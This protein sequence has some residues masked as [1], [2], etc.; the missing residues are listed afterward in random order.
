[1]AELHRINRRLFLSDVGRRTVAIAVL[2][3]GVL[4]ACSSDGELT[5]ETPSNEPTTTST[6]A[7]TTST[8]T[9]E[10]EVTTSTLSS[11]S[12]EDVPPALAWQRVVLGG[13]SAYVL[14]R[15]DEVTI[16]DTG[17]SGSAPQIEEALMTLGA[18]WSHVG[19]VIL[20]HLHSDHIG[21]LPGILE[22]TATATVHAGRA[23]VEAITASREVQ[24]LDDGDEIFGLQ[25]IATP[26]HTPGHIAVLD[27]A[28]GL[29]VAG[30]ALNESDGMVLGP[31]PSFTPD[32]NTANASVQRL[33]ERS[34]ET[35]VFG[36]GNPI[37]G[38][39]SDA[40]VALAQT[41]S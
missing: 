31:N 19:R 25:I 39:A 2:G 24:A 3:P 40:V 37:E 12:A 30:D 32:M 26:G 38:G 15:G 4:A 6:A 5:L 21:G 18:D 11:P 33:A 41:L 14:A 17:R 23:D 7:S 8:E 9:S 29:L 1:M 22:E 36:H 27:P 13:V 10:A 28:A 34:F 16:V 35:V 20:T